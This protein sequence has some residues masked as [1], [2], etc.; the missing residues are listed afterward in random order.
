MNGQ[1]RSPFLVLL[2][3]ELG[4]RQVSGVELILALTFFYGPWVLLNILM[5]ALGSDLTA[6]Y[7]GM[8]GM[9]LLFWLLGA[10][11]M[12]T[13]P[14]VPLVW[15]NM[16]NFKA[17]EF[18]FT[19]AID[20]RLNFRA[21]AAAAL[22]MVLA[23]QLPGFVCSL[24][25]PDM[26]VTQVQPDMVVTPNMVP[27]LD[28]QAKTRGDTI[29]GRAFPTERY[30]QAFPGSV[31]APAPKPNEH[32]CLRIRHGW[33]TYTCWLAWT[34]TLLTTL[35]FAYYALAGRHLRSSGWWANTV[36]IAPIPTVLGAVV[37]AIWLGL[38]PGDELFLFFRAH[39]LVCALVLAGT[40]Y[41]SLRWCERRFAELEIV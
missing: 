2:K 33:L 9:L 39:R 6:F 34:T 4:A 17:F 29:E 13:Y 12:A 22:I 28:V 18:Q 10:C 30:F 36:L 3:H 32:G 11:A 35:F 41:V 19:R 21:K 27:T 15:S 14:Q 16:T 24:L 38:N 1:T 7:P 31:R 5:S 40:C 20:R 25:H 8:L 37:F 26:V 23:P